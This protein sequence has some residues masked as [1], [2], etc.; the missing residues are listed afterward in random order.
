M[1]QDCPFC[2]MTEERIISNFNHFYVVR[3]AYPVTEHHSLII[4]KNHDAKLDSMTSDELF[5]LMEITKIV[6]N[7]ILDMDIKV[8][9]FN[10]GINEG[11]AAGQTVMH[12]HCHVIPRR[13]GDTKNPRGGVRGV[14]P[15]KQSY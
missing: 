6:K 5:E 13:E 15:N 7:Q 9:G 2:D 8:T 14:I 1:K 12:F 3:D 10:I 4:S 11:T